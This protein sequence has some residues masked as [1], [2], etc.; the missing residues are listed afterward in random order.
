MCDTGSLNTGGQGRNTLSY[1]TFDAHRVPVRKARADAVAARN[2]VDNISFLKYFSIF[3]H[4]S[5]ECR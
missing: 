2:F 5:E 3:E 1:S 4:Y